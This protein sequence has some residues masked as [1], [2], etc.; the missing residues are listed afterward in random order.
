M[1]RPKFTFI[2]SDGTPINNTNSTQET[3]S[4]R[5]LITDEML[6]KVATRCDKHSCKEMGQVLGVDG[7]SL[8]QRLN[9][10]LTFEFV[11]KDN[12]RV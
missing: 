1:I 8:N 10:N 7:K 6:A 12:Q 3:P 5:C 11:N 4:K 9:R 2:E